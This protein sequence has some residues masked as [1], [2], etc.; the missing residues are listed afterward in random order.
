[1]TTRAPGR[2]VVSLAAALSIAAAF[3][4]A[5]VTEAAPPK[6]GT[7]ARPP[8]RATKPTAPPPKPPPPLAI[9]PSVARVRLEVS[10]TSLVVATEVNLPRGAW[11]GEALDF[12]VAFGA[13][14]APRAV[15]AHLVP[16]ADGHLEPAEDEVGE[17]LPTERAP[18]RPVTSH[19]LLGRDTMA[20]VVVHV[21]GEALSR[22][23]EGGG[24]AAL[25][26]RT[27]VE[28]P[29]ED[30]QGGRSAVVRL[31]AALGEPLTLGRV[32]VVA[33]GMTVRRAEAR[34]CGSSASPTPL[35][36]GIEPPPQATAPAVPRPLAPVLA[37]RTPT[38]DL[39]VRFWSS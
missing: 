1:M 32:T 26:V 38:D 39:C 27:A 35:A 8:P 19:P 33:R 25:R 6:R 24:M 17:A 29:G 22:A 16:V 20:G 14:G 23:L 5:G 11:R 13:P 37:V 12:Y 21:G 34:L 10:R 7:S 31:G 30:P 36:V 9:R 28:L 2:L 15:D 3:S 18:R 4:I